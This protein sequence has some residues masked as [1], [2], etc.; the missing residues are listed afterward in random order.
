[1]VVGVGSWRDGE[2]GKNGLEWAH[3]YGGRKKV[4]I[5]FVQ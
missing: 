5:E 1:M 3:E 4:P 2:G